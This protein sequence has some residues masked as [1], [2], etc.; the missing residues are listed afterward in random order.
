VR[1]TWQAGDADYT[2]HHQRNIPKKPVPWWGSVTVLSQEG[3]THRAS[4]SS[5][6]KKMLFTQATATIMTLAGELCDEYPEDMP[7]NISFEL[8]SR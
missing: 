4:W 1:V 2:N 6:G 3:E 5:K 7:L 8:N